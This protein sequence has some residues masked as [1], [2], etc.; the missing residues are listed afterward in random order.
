MHNFL[1]FFFIMSITHFLSLLKN[2]HTARISVIEY[3][4]S[5]Q[6]LPILDILQDFGYIRGYRI[7]H[8]P[9]GNPLK[10]RKGITSGIVEILSRY[11]N[12]R[13][14]IS[15]IK[16]NRPFY[17]SS[18]NLSSLFGHGLFIIPTSQGLMSHFTAH[19]LHIGG[20]VLC[21]IS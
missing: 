17:I 8:M 15:D 1:F 3:P 5:K 2:A 4:P 18:N 21:H 10:M 13:P 6:I 9:S 14:A 12:R 16:K 11:K 19:K 7:N 20:Q